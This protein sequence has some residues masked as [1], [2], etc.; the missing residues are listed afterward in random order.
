MVW[1]CLRSV[2]SGLSSF[3]ERPY[4]SLVLS[5]LKGVRD[6]ELCVLFGGCHVDKA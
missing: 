4:V 5:G 3:L 2:E 6:L 1:E